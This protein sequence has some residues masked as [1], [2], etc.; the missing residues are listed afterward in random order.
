MIPGPLALRTPASTHHLRVAAIQFA[1]EK[2]KTMKLIDSRLN[3]HA[4]LLAE[5]KAWERRARM[6]LACLTQDTKHCTNF[7]EPR[8]PHP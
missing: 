7:H 8:A 3:K 1:Q 4:V 2:F 5:P 6:L